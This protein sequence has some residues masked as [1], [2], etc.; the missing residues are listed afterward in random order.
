M[1]IDSSKKKA[2]LIQFNDKKTVGKELPHN[3][4]VD[5]IKIMRE[6]GGYS[7]VFKESQL[8]LTRE[9]INRWL[10]NSYEKQHRIVDFLEIKDV[11]SFEEFFR[12][13]Q[14]LRVMPQDHILFMTFLYYDGNNDGYICDYDLER[15]ANLSIKRPVIAHDHKKL[16]QSNIKK[17]LSKKPAYLDLYK[18]S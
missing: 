15:M 9:S 2:A 7:S 1:R 11:V 3:E 13:S 18:L 4:Q 8:T 10:K 5:V 14:R 6:I 17:V 16:R 12:I